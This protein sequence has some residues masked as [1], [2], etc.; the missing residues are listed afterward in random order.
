MQD[1][2]QF[3]FPSS[4]ASSNLRLVIDVEDGCWRKR[5][6][7]MVGLMPLDGFAISQA[8]GTGF[9]I[10]RAGT[11]QR[12]RSWTYARRKRGMVPVKR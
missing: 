3:F 11:V 8:M 10:C 7:A 12:V 6:V 4:V 9:S 5:M 1:R 2:S